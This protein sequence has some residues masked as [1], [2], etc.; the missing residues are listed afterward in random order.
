MV[1]ED[2]RFRHDEVSPHG[3][4]ELLDLDLFH[5]LVVFLGSKAVARAADGQTRHPF[6]AMARSFER[7]EA[8][9]LLISVA[10]RVR[11]ILDTSPSAEWELKRTAPR[12][13]G[14]LSVVVSDSGRR[15]RSALT[16][17]EA[18][19]KIIHARHI[20]FDS[21]LSGRTLHPH[22]GPIVYLYG[23]QRGQEWKATLRIPEFVECAYRT[24]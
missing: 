18:C 22:I 24:S 13:V 8:A 17:R 16:F 21:R 14:T 19:N 6:A 1:E 9:R 20:T 3:P 4:K 15:A 2:N 5:L 11:G 12:S 10:V 23:D 7:S